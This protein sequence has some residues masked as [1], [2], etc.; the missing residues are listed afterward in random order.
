MF[1]ESIHKESI[2]NLF[3]NELNIDLNLLN[4]IY[5]QFSSLYQKENL[6]FE[7]YD[8]KISINEL[9]K[10]FHPFV[11]NK[12]SFGVDLPVWFSES[13]KQRPKLLLLAMDPLRNFNNHDKISFNSPF[14]IHLSENNNYCSSI[15]ELSNNYDVYITDIFK[16]FFRDNKDH[17]NVS[18][19]NPDFINL[20][21]H[22]RIIQ[23]EIKIFQ[24]DMILCLGKHSL[25]GLHKLK[26]LHP[27]PQSTIGKLTEYT[28]QTDFKAIPTFAIPHASGLASRWAK[29]FLINNLWGKQYSGKTYISDAVEITLKKINQ[30]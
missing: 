9:N 6:E 2:L 30:N 21:I 19:K 24:P 12:C 17:K 25:A 28:F 15:K 20:D 16:L 8:Q 27:E 5:R 29:Q 26:I 13:K 3:H 10:D 7:E 18:N 4:Q 22:F 11:L 1:V 14:S 23:E